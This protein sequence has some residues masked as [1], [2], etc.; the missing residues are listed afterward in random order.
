MTDRYNSVEWVRDNIESFGGD[1]KK[2]T[3][4]GQS[5][6][7][8]D[9]DLYSLAWYE[10]PIVSGLIMDS[11]TGLTFTGN[12][13]YYSNFTYVA[14]QVGCGNAT[15]ESEELACMKTIDADKIEAVLEESWNSYGMVM[16]N[17]SESMALSFGPSVDERTIFST[18]ARRIQ[19]G[20]VANVVSTHFTQTC[21]KQ[22]S[23]HID[24]ALSRPSS[25]SIRTKALTW[26]RLAPMD[27]IRRLRR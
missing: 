15:T 20:Q 6:G 11:C 13:P 23:M 17:Q 4:W 21:S 22:I 14:N 16:G 8:S 2:I 18:Y 7:A 25:A 5:S 12:T 19:Q 3:I 9:V 24:S 10:D 1:A 26:H 27:Q